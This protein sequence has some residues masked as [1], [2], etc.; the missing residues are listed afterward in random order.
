MRIESNSPHI[1]NKIKPMPSQKA[2]AG[3]GET[4]TLSEIKLNKQS[5]Q[6][7]IINWFSQ[8]GVQSDNSHLKMSTSNEKI[9]GKAIDFCLEDGKEEELDPD[10]FFSFVKMAEKIFLPQ[11]KSYG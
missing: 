1:I 8:V 9:L 4:R 2:A 11:C 7:R 3:V 10:W 5:S 6:Q